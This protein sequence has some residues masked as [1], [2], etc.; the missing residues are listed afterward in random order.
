MRDTV[1]LYDLHTTYYHVVGSDEKELEKRPF[2]DLGEA[3]QM[4]ALHNGNIIKVTKR[5]KETMKME[6]AV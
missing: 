5:K 6:K 1:T 4:A 3:R 2:H